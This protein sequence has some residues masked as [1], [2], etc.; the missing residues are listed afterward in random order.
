MSKRLYIGNLAYSTM[1]HTLRDAFA[2][3][4]EVTSATVV[5]DRVSGQSRGFGFVEFATD[6][7][8]NAAQELN[9]TVLDG[10]PI[11]VGPARARGEGGGG[12]GGGRGGGPRGG[13]GFRG[14]GGGGGGGGWQGGGGGGPRGGGGGGGGGGRGGGGGGG[15]R[16]R[17]RRG[18]RRDGG[19][20]W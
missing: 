7:A 4:G 1:E 15:G 13:G 19:D 18:Q 12:G 11:V 2:R 16:D 20:D 3:Y 8:A 9:G 17:G 10:R 6:E 5:I 14:G